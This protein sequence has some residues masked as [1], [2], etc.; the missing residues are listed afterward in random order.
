M[1][2]ELKEKV[3]EAN[4]LLPKLNLVTFTW[5]NVSAIDRDNGVF[6]IKPS[7]VS[8]EKMKVDDIVVLN[9]DGKVIEGKLNP[10][11]D[12]P[13]H[14]VLYKAWENV[15]SIVHTHST[16]ATSWAQS[17]KEIPAFGTTH[18]DYFRSSIPLARSLRK[19]ELDGEYEKNTGF[20][21]LEAFQ[22]RDYIAT[23]AVLCQNH[24]P[25][26][27]G[28][29]TKESVHNAKV[30]EEVAKMAFITLSINKDSKEAPIELQ[31]RHYFRKHGENATYG[32]KN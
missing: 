19:D 32:Q 3:L 11:S 20:V 23:P 18:A 16:F 21:I 13:T 6:A 24:G 31:D 14:L 26:A 28:K 22:N 1:Y 27:W 30:L 9:L 5:G 4:L 7:G 29:D 25:F 8:Y 15:G 2:R 17:G 10:S 12:T